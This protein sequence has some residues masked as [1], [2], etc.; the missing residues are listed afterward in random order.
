MNKKV[1]TLFY[2]LL[3][4]IIREALLYNYFHLYFLSVVRCIH[5]HVIKYFFF[6]YF[7]LSFFWSVYSSLIL[8]F[9]SYRMENKFLNFFLLL[10][11]LNFFYYWLFPDSLK[12]FIYTHKNSSLKSIT[13]M[14]F[15]HTFLRISRSH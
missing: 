2:F 1:F 15:L 12:L 5:V 10:S 9:N 14:I 7:L 11:I 4:Y 13:K 3:F 8:P 6:S